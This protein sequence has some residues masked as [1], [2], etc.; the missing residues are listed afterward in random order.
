MQHIRHVAVHNETGKDNAVQFDRVRLRE[1]A[2]WHRE[3]AERAGS[4]V[5]W[6]ARRRTA[7]ALDEEADRLERISA[8]EPGFW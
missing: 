5:V 7:E 3:Q 1:L 2:A 6:D 8:V 4:V